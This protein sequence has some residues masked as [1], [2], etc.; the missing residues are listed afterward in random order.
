[1]MGSKGTDV[2]VVGG[3][4]GGRGQLYGMEPSDGPSPPPTQVTRCQPPH[5]R[6]CHSTVTRESKDK[7]EGNAACG[8]HRKLIILLLYGIAV[9]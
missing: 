9:G 8:L 3:G 2:E 4:E 6:C 1:M 5:W 7:L